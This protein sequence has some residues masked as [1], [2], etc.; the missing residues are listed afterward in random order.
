MDLKGCIVTFD[1][2][3]TQKKTCR[4][5][6][7]KKGHYIGG[8]KENQAGLLSDARDCFTED[9]LKKCEAAPGRDYLKTSEKMHSQI[10]TREYYRVK[11]WHEPSGDDD[12]WAGLKSFIMVKKEC[13]SL[14]T[15]RKTKETRYYISDLTDIEALAEG[16]RGHWSIENCLHF[17]LDYTMKQ[18]KDT[19]T[20]AKADLHMGMIK[21]MAL[22]II[23]LAKPILGN[24]SL[25]LTGKMIGM[26]VER[27]MPAVFMSL[28]RESIYEALSSVK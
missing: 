13:E 18:D 16:I 22:S 24:K 19:T 12:V 9:A 26:D 7:D 25:K 10:E 6:K 1:A 11:A 27:V 3:N 21:K 5:I 28:S 20:D 17:N 14:I 15:A 2:L 23:R 8:L 4:I